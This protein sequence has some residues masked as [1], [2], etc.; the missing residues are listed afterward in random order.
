MSDSNTNIEYEVTPTSQRGKV[1]LP[2]EGAN[3]LLKATARLINVV[4]SAAEGVGK[5][6][7]NSTNAIGKPIEAI[8]EGTTSEIEL[9]NQFITARLAY[10]REVNATM[11]TANVAEEFNKKVE[12]GEEIPEKIEPSDKLN[13]IQERAS[14]V[15][16]EEFLK[17][18][19]K[20]YTEEVCNPDSISKKTINLLGD[21]DYNIVKILEQEIFPFCDENGF[22]WGSGNRI[23]AI[24]KAQEYGIIQNILLNTFANNINLVLTKKINEQISLYLYPNYIYKPNTN[25]MLTTSG[26]EIRNILKIYPKEENYDEI[27]TELSKSS[28][29][30]SIAEPYKNKIKMHSQ[31]ANEQ[32]FILCNKSEEI[33]YPTNQIYKTLNEFYQNAMS[34]I[35]VVENGK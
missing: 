34:N 11:F 6:L 12:N 2:N 26:I 10:V 9:R 29:S 3:E 23:E 18:W 4:N 35:E 22:Y 1:V 32:K 13:T 28:N 8:L 30:W 16:N 19:S 27:F 25:F 21:M 24:R 33:V 7:K 5:M 15:S 20:F 14:E 31:I 17:L